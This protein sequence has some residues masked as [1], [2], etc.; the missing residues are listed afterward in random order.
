MQLIFFIL[1]ILGESIIF[2]KRK[3]IDKKV[4][5]ISI[6]LYVLV[7]LFLFVLNRM[8]FFFV[9]I[10]FRSIYMNLIVFLAI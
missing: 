5:I 4:L 7:T 9:N 6:I 10:W 8:G 3:K 2:I 1:G